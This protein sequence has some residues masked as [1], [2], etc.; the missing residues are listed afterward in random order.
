[1][2]KFWVS[3]MS[4]QENKIELLEQML[5]KWGARLND[6]ETDYALL[7]QMRRRQS[8]RTTELEAILAKWLPTDDGEQRTENATTPTC[9]IT[10]ADV[11]AALKTLRYTT[12]LSLVLQRDRNGMRAVLAADRMRKT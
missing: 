11:E 4:A 1:M 10:D 8:D 7:E 12:G 6:L 3:I 5:R 2:A 9:E